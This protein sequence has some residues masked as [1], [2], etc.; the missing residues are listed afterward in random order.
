MLD[1]LFPGLSDRYRATYGNA[2]EVVSEN[3][4]RL[5]A[6]F[7]AICESHGILH[8][9]EQC[10]AYLRALPEENSQ[11]SLFEGEAPD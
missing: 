9:P 5:M 11:L 10:F 7:H 4:D 8:D 1:K 2:Y 6:K 3:S